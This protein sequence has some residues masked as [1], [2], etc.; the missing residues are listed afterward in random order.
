MASIAVTGSPVVADDDLTL[1]AA[2]LPP[3]QWSFFLLSQSQALVP[4]FGGSQGVL[5]LGAPIVRLDRV[6]LGELGQ[7]TSAGTRSVA[8]DLSGLP[9]G[10]QLLPG[11]SWSFQLWF[12]DANPQPTSNTSDATA[13]LFR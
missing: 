1:E 11:E 4:G 8:V 5:C 3:G 7:V 10:T 6:A 2:G 9:Q 13:V 12:R